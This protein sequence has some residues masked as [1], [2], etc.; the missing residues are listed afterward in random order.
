MKDTLLKYYRKYEEIINYLIVGVMTTIVS[1]AAKFIC[2]FT[3]LSHYQ[4]IVW[5]NMLL[6]F[7]NWTTGVIFAYFTNRKFVFK[8]TETNMLKEATKFVGSRIFTLF[9]DMAV[10]FIMNNVCGI[11]IFISTV[12]SAV[13]VVIANY[14]FSKL[15]VFTKKAS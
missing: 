7:I 14:I 11:D 4:E 2:A 15:M 13:L 8:S 5:Q 12:T 1:W 10:Q 6:A 3:F 9:L